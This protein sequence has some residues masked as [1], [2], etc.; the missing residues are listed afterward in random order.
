MVIQARYGKDSM[1]LLEKRIR[2]YEKTALYSIS[3]EA[4]IWGNELFS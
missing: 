2:R 3:I 4:E 1:N